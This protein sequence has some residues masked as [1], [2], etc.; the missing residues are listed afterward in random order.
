MPNVLRALLAFA[1]VTLGAG[2]A[3]AAPDVVATPGAA[4][5]PGQPRACTYDPR[6]ITACAPYACEP[7]VP[8]STPVN[9]I[10]AGTPGFCGRCTNDRFCGGAACKADGRCSPYD[11]SPPPQP[12]WPRFHLLVTNAAINFIDS[13]SPKPIVGVGYMFQGAFSRTAPQKF[14]Q[15]GWYTPD[16][17]RAYFNA[18]ASVA[19]AGPAQNAFVELGA[20]LYLPS[21]PIAITTLSVGAEYQRQG[22]SIWKV[23]N[24]DENEDRLGPSV[25]VGFLQNVFVRASYVF[26]LRG[27]NDHG[28]LIVGIAYM[29]DLLGDL[30]PDRFQRF[31]PSNLK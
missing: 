18:S 17:P 20:T 29:K 26:P 7:D 13:T 31:L 16:L 12:V 9:Q 14:N 4:A 21:A 25:S 22:A 30:V 5:A 11:A 8:A 24:D 15:R 6:D 27:P 2:V 3:A 28:A 10:R 19:M 23:G 1:V